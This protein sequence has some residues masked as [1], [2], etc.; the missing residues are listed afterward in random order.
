MGLC[1]SSP[2]IHAPDS[3]APNLLCSVFGLF[4]LPIGS[5]TLMWERADPE[6]FLLRT[7]QS[8]LGPF[9]YGLAMENKVTLAVGQLGS[10]CVTDAACLCWTCGFHQTPRLEAPELLGTHT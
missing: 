9:P 6:A 5:I 8:M 7:S 3:W 10:I 1:L 4:N 2:W